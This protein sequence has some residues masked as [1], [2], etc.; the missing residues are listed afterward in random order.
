PA[1]PPRLCAVPAVA[2][3]APAPRSALASVQEE[4]LAGLRRALTQPA[5]LLGRRQELDRRSRKG[6][7]RI[8]EVFADP[9]DPLAVSAVHR[10]LGPRGRTQ[11]F[12]AE[13]R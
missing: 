5:Q 8:F 13:E 7:D 2:H 11:S 12:L 4:P 6:A 9:P 10:E 1:V 3:V